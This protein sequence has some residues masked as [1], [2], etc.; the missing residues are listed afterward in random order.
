MPDWS[1]WLLLIIPVLIP[2]VT[3][4]ILWLIRERSVRAQWIIAVIA[5]LFGWILTLIYYP[6]LAIEASVSVWLP[7]DIFA[8]PVQI[9]LGFGNWPLLLAVQSVLLAGAILQLSRPIRREPSIQI[10]AFLYIGAASLAVMAGNILTIILVW[11]LFDISNFLLF[12]VSQGRSRAISRAITR[13]SIDAAGTL[14]LLAATLALNNSSLGM[15]TASGSSSNI[16]AL[17]IISA[18]LLRSGW[19]PLQLISEPAETDYMH[20]E[21]MLRLVPLGVA[22]LPLFYYSSDLDMIPLVS[23]LSVLL[24]LGMIY[25]ALRWLF[26]EGNLSV[27]PYF[28]LAFIVYGIL[29][30]W[31]VGS[32]STAFM[33]A[34]V[35]GILVG[36]VVGIGRIHERLHRV[37]LLISAIIMLGLPFTS[38]GISA[39]IVAT[40]IVERQSLSVIIG[41]LIIAALGL[42]GLG[43]IRNSMGDVTDWPAATS[44][45]RG[46]YSIALA[47]PL[48]TSVIIGIVDP[49][50][51]TIYGMILF[52]LTST[53]TA[54]LYYVAIRLSE[55]RYQ[56]IRSRLTGLNLGGTG[57]GFIA[58]ISGITRGL[59]AIG[60]I[61]E[62]EG[63]MLWLFVI[64][65]VLVIALGEG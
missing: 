9:L 13:L 44:Q 53:V 30:W 52:V 32:E 48:I 26:Q 6:F 38:G 33:S 28:N 3:G 37:L 51:R 7:A 65:A 60:G 11:T 12:T 49:V 18:V 35:T 57:R 4:L 23:V 39:T 14:L 20:T 50:S 22:A 15:A 41:P 54:G 56:Q 59:R 17:L 40:S 43:I 10:A 62:G 36:T 64:L 29:L 5:S 63:A 46:V 24:A 16:G 1:A 25:A 45:G 61:F 21:T 2:I 19:Y 8:T 34:V 55:E 47:S 42:I 31:L 58:I 27:Q